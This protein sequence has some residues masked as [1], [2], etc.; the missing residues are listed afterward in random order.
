MRFFLESYGCT[1]NYGEGDQLARRMCELGHTPVDD[2]EE[3]DIVILNTCTVIDTTEK[4]MLRRMSELRKAGKKV[5]VTGCMAKVQQPR[6]A[7]RLPDAVIVPPDMYPSFKDI[8]SGSYGCSEPVYDPVYGPSAILPIAQGCLGNCSYCITRFAR[9]QL[10]SCPE[11]E[12]LEQFS[13][14]IQSGTKEI[15]VTA[16]DS[17]CYGRD[18]GTSL[19]VLLK[20]MLEFDGDWRIRVGM[21]NPNSLDPVLDDVLDAMEDPRIYRFFHIPVQSGSDAVLD[22]MKRHYTADRFMGLI[23]RIRDR[24]PDASIATDIITGFPGETDKDHDKTMALVRTLRADTL[25][26]TRFSARPGTEASGMAE[27]QGNVAKERSRELTE[28]KNLTEYDVNSA[29][30]G[31]SYRVLVTEIG[32]PG[33]VITRTSNYR[34]VAIDG[35]Y[36]IGTFLNVEVTDHES[37]YLHGNVK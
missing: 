28:L 4:K 3:A 33:T 29:M 21:T 25:N 20:K 8:V 30:V 18:T 26:I 23:N 22:K 9:G 2:V 5:V 16:Q 13:N 35:D 27:V 31:K 19:G 36:T 6:I 17:A 15:L 14:M 37:T 34:P 12:I 32:K 11:E 1:M 10:L 24:Y 7:I